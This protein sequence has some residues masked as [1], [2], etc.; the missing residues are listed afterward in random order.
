MNRRALLIAMALAPPAHAAEPF[1]RGGWAAL[2]ASFA[3]RATIV[4][5]WSLTCAPCMVELA[6]WPAL[7]R[8]MPG[9]S[10][11]LVNTDAPDQAAAIAR[12]AQRAGLGGLRQYA[13]A[14]GFAAR[15]RWEIDPSW[16]GELPRTEL[17][18]RD[19]T[20]HHLLG[21]IDETRLIT[22]ARGQLP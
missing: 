15:L 11:V 2:R 8:R 12:A 16:Q 1:A 18:D 22:W 7:A 13:F 19:G 17:L 6:Q 14:D 5:F 3:G 21:T 10:V 20:Q 9:I 4:H